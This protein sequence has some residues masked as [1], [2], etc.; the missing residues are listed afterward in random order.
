MKYFIFY[1]IACCLACNLAAQQQPTKVGIKKKKNGFQLT[2][3][4]KPYFIKGAVGNNYL[5]KLKQY[6]GNSIRTGS[7]KE[8]LDQ[9]LS[10]GLTA[11]VNLPVRAERDGMNYDDTALVRK[12]H[13]RVM[14]IVRDTKDHPAV[15]MWALGNELDFIQ[16]NVKLHYNTKVWDAV[17]ALAKE[18][19]EIDP[20]HP[21]MTVVG[22]IN[23]EKISD[24]LRLCP[25]L[26]L[27]GVNEYGDLLK[28]P[29]WLRQFGWKKPYAVTEWG[30]TGFW[31]VPKTIWKVPIEETSS[32][33]AAKYKERYEKAIAADKNCIGSYVFLWRQHQ[34]RTHTWF[35]MFDANGKETEAV[36]VMYYEWKGK[37]PPNRTPR[38]DSAK[39]ENMTAYQNVYLKKGEAYTAQVWASDPDK[40]MLTYAWE[41]LPEGSNFPYGG[42]GEKKP[43]AISGLIDDGEKSRISFRSPDKEGSYRLFVYVYDGKGHF[44]TANVPFYVNQ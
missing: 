37:W 30:P 40:D 39:I 24:L 15:I 18:I 4:G 1:L 32:M 34:E 36:D 9:A 8:T 12:Q 41:I 5:E 33:K 43:E 3:K 27:L 42:G 26:D 29:E 19:H 44:A 25:D 7:K 6:G 20:F 14:A 28:I 11:L 16:A 35:G 31:Q 22:S 23:P 17:N 10:L 21:V 38:L 13:E 2:V